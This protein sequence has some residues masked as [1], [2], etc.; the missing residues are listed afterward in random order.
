MEAKREVDPIA[1]AVRLEQ[2]LAYTIGFLDSVMKKLSNERF[3]A[4]A[5]ADVI[6][7][8][9]QKASDAEK[10]IMALREELE[11]LSAKK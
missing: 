10:K 9:R 3:V 7:R 4:N 11:R 5:K 6:D 8:E 2:E 1:E